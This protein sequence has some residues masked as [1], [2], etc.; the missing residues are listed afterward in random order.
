[1]RKW[2]MFGVAL[3]LVKLGFIGSIMVKNYGLRNKNTRKY[4]FLVFFVTTILEVSILLICF[5]LDVNIFISG[6]IREIGYFEA[7]AGSYRNIPFGIFYSM[8]SVL[9]I[10]FT[11]ITFKFYTWDDQARKNPE[12]LEQDIELENLVRA[13]G[14]S[15][16]AAYHSNRLQP[17]PI[18]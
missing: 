2:S 8:R 3:V 5:L 10:C 1:M 11:I 9:D 14:E 16:Y 12:P 13:E 7:L 18:N 15:V 4:L 17:E 6:K